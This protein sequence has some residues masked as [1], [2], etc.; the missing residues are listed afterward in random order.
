VDATRQLLAEGRSPTVEEAAGRAGISR[1]T[2]Y[3]YF[4]N[5]RTLLVAAYPELA[6]QSLLPA[7]AP[8]T[9]EERLD[10]AVDELISRVLAHEPELRTMLRLSLEFDP[11]DPA[12]LPLRQGRAAIWM[13]DALTPLKGE[14]QPD[15]VRRLALAIRV[16]TGIE[17]LVWLTD[18]AGI[19][20]TEAVAL[21]KWSAGALLRAA[22]EAAP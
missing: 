19:P 9:V 16:A 12:H 15:A 14:L 10:A 11:P 4:P 8:R 3:R 6:A 17:A 20:R 5:Q 22:R 18:A 13:E 2:A 1:A 7:D 21:M